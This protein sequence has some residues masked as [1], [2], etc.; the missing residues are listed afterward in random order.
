[1]ATDET[2]LLADFLQAW[3]SDFERQATSQT[4]GFSP[5][6]FMYEHCSVIVPQAF[7]DRVL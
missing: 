5:S 1:M 6:I 2:E 7:V 4:P 3:H